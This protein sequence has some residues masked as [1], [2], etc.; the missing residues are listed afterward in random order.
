MNA[1]RNEAT[2]DVKIIALADAFKNRVDSLA[3]NLT[4]EFPGKTD[5]PEE[6]RFVGLDCCEQLLKTDC[7]VVLL[8]EPPGFRPRNFVAAANEGV[9]RPPRPC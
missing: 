1:L 8:C 3:Q 2:S 9:N 5:I 6:R 4:R 7:D